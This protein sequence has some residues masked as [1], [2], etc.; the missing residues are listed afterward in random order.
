M[1]IRLVF[2][3]NNLNI[4]GPQKG[5]VALL[6]E[7]DE[8]I[9][10]VTVVS[11]QPGGELRS[12][13]ERNTPVRDVSTLARAAQ[14]NRETPLRD[15]WTLFR[16]RRFCSIW[17][18]FRGTF[19]RITNR[20]VNPWRQRVWSAARVPLDTSLGTFDAAFAVSS[21]LASYYLVDCVSSRRRFHW[22]IGDY[23][24]TAID[25]AIDRSY[26]LR[27]DGALSVS[28]AC[29]DIFRG[30]FP[31][32]DLNIR[33]FRQLIPWRFYA[34][35]ASNSPT[36]ETTD[37]TL[38]VLTV[39]RLDP[40]K[41]LDL[42]VDACRLLAHRGRAVEWLV[43]G[44]GDQRPTL[45]RAIKESGLQGSMRLLGFR[46]NVADFLS[47]AD[48]FVLPSRT[49]GRSS[50]VD[51]A[52]AMGVPVVVTNYRT[53]HTQVHSGVLGVICSMEGESLA[54]AIE[55]L[56]AAEDR[57]VPERTMGNQDP[58][59]LFLQLTTG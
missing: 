18:Y 53:A 54:D 7:L 39:T 27:M 25:G 56:A 8:D 48:V 30:V 15:V 59:P 23:S 36:F 47:S 21:G 44:D 5:L 31:D 43:L 29:S 4:G 40:E 41:G 33:E 9:F 32:L 35:N 16:F 45:E 14:M 24:R 38:R 46:T 49:E 1:K 19:A 37:D 20:P 12:Y 22:I 50:A 52:I 6:D 13:I 42:A 28:A 58:S 2:I 51:E 10:D 3:A 17:N 57:G 34:E 11:M 26:F 55:R